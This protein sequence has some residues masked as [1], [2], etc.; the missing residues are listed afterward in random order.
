M[1]ITWKPLADLPLSKIDQTLRDICKANARA[2]Y[3]G[4]D[5]QER[6]VIDRISNA[7]IE[8]IEKV[9]AELLKEGITVF[10]GYR[11]SVRR[12]QQVP[13]WYCVCLSSEPILDRRPSGVR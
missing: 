8:A 5:T 12:H 9:S 1:S 7:L 10:D 4:T 13:T 6:A 3:W 2:Q 11:C